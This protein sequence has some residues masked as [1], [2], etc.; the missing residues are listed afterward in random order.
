VVL[1]HVSGEGLVS[2]ASTPPQKR[3]LVE[4]ATRRDLIL[5]AWPSQWGQEILVVDDLRH[6]R[7]AVAD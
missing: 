4:D 1:I 6:A 2:I 7:E 3:R 5:V